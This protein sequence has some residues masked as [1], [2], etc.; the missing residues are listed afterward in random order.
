MLT[1]SELAALASQSYGPYWQS[2]LARDLSINTRTVQRWAVDGIGR[3]AMAD[4]V[5]RFLHERRV[6]VIP[7]PDAS[8]SEDERDEACHEGL[9]P[10]VI[11]LAS[12]AAQHGWNPAEIWVAI[13]AI[14]AENICD[15]AGSPAAVDVL[16]Q[17][18]AA[19]Q[20]D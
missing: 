14:A 15:I 5:R 12:A 4:N 10:A 18:I 19:I 13:V 16:N 6:V 1:P 7:P 2:A 11:A 3:K 9:E 20:D 8:M 17:T